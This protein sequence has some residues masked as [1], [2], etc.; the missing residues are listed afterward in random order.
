MTGVAGIAP[1]GTI[2]YTFWTNGTC[3]NTGSDAGSSQSL[4]SSSSIEGPLAA[5]SYS[6]EAAYS[7]DSNYASS[8]S[9]CEPFTVDGDGTATVTT[10]VDD[11]VLA[12]A[13]NGHEDLGSKAYD[14][15]MV[16][17]V[18]GIVPTGTISYAF[19][20]N[21]Y[22]SGQSSDAGTSLLLGSQST[23]EGPLGGGSY[24]F[25]AIYSGDSNYGAS[26][27]PCEPFSVNLDT[28]ETASVVDNSQT[29]SGWGG[30][31]V[32]GRR[33]TTLRP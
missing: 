1:T 25:V 18:G 3:A 11:A 9:G 13:W 30:N 26:S 2:T 28:P 12:A 14:T 17:G 21:G 8:T 15:S 5:G 10:T 33:R 24:S 7:G 27:S 20:T 16:T 31:E 23:T 29:N 32:T 4:G 6:F 19:W 22:C